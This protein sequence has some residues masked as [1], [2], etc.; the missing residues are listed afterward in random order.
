LTTVKD[1]DRLEPYIAGRDREHVGSR[2]EETSMVEEKSGS[3][4]KPA[5]LPPAQALALKDLIAVQAGAIVSRELKRTTGGTVTLFAFDGGQGL[6]EHTAPFDALVQVVEGSLE[7][8]IGGVPVTTRAG[9]V[10]LMPANVP[11]ALLAP[12]PAKMLLVML[13]TLGG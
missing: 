6:S 2:Q 9:E 3:S 11:H 5:G 12:Q 8:R 10:V 1:F 4:E 7:I 13:R